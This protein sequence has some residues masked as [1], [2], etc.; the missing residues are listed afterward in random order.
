MGSLHIQ[1]RD[2]R[3]VRTAR[4]FVHDQLDSWGLDDLS[5]ALELAASEMVTNALIHAGSDVDV[6]LR[7]FPD[8]VR[9][10]VRDSDS[11]PPSPRPV[12]QRGGQRGSG[13]R[14]RHADRGGL[15]RDV[16]E[17]PNG[18]GKTV[19]LNLPISPH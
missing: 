14:P 17:L 18:Q 2:L 15:G 11:N 5:E 12:P 3:G 10:E 6:R 7:A 8:H 4:A 13:A 9:L 19:S 1:R 16:E